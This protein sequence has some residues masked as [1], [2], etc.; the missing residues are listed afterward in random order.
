L[1]QLSSHAQ[2]CRIIVDGSFQE[3]NFRDT[4]YVDAVQ[5]FWDR[6]IFDGKLSATSNQAAFEEAFLDEE[7]YKLLACDKEQGITFARAAFREYSKNRRAERAK[8]LSKLR[9]RSVA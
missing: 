5:L 1:H 9:V 4:W 2:K 6:S 7:I 8:Q 3:P